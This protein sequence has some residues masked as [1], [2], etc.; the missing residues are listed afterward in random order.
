[1]SFLE[2]MNLYSALDW[3]SPYFTLTAAQSE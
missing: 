3:H 1:M 2:A